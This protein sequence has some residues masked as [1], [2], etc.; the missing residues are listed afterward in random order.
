MLDPEVSTLTTLNN[1]QNSFVLPPPIGRFFSRAPAY[2]LSRIPTSG[3]AA[4]AE[5]VREDRDELERRDTALQQKAT[6]HEEE[7]EEER[8]SHDGR[9]DRPQLTHLSSKLSS[10]SGGPE[11]PYAVLPHGVSLEGWTEDEKEELNDYVRHLLHSRK[12]K[13][14]RKMKGFGKY[15]RTR[16]AYKDNNGKP[17]STNQC[18]SHRCFC[19]HILVSINILGCGLG[20]IPHRWVLA[21][22]HKAI[23]RVLELT[24]YLRVATR[25]KPPGVLY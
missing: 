24:P 15:V 11:R 17:F 18:D 22:N 23:R 1:Y 5:T 20:V 7:D 13:F 14:R 4:T 6:I 10:A 12:A 8:E 2:D 3:T 25:W 9:P 21:A 19:H 16:K